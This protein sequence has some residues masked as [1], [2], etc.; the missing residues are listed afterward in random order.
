ML[1][2]GE[3]GI[4]RLARI[5][6]KLDRASRSVRRMPRRR[7]RPAGLSGAARHFARR[8]APVSASARLGSARSISRVSTG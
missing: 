1:G 5:G 4:L 3:E 2:I 8:S 7:R 6:S